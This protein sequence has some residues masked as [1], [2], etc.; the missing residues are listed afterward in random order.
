LE[1]ILNRKRIII[2]V[3]LAVVIGAGIFLFSGKKSSK[4]LAGDQAKPSLTVTTGSPDVRNWSHRISATGNVQAWQEAII[5][6]EV[7]GLR[8]AELYVNVGDA[9]KKGQLLAK[10][11][12]EMTELD[13]EQQRAAVDEARARFVQAE[14]K[15][16]SSQKL[17]D[18]GM[19]ST[20]DNIQNQSAAQIA[21]AQLKAAEARVKAQALRLAYTRVRAP[22][23]GIISSRTATV[24]SVLQTGN[25]MFRYLRRNKLE[26]RAEVPDGPLQK[27]RVGQKVTLHTAQGEAVA[28]RVTRISPVVDAQS[29]NGSVYIELSGTKNLKAGMFAQGEL[30]LGRTDAIT[31]AQ[32]AV[33]VRDGYSYVFKVGADERVAQV[34]VQV[35]RRMEGRIEVVEG[36]AAD[37]QIVTAGAGFLNDGDLVRIANAGSV[38][39]INPSKTN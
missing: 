24:G 30:E 19:T 25:E 37:A 23:D 2:L 16:E 10:F 22:D 39:R 28:G 12:D 26:W 31:V 9:V 27:I 17:K 8:L 14:A 21:R 32:N 6:S 35:G 29:R 36:I 33:V 15:A 18:A 20:L 7:A 3:V 34:K 5:G 38:K 1:N 4:P 13:L 11:T